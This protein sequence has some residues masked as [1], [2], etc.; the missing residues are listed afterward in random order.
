MH[1]LSFLLFV[2]FIQEIQIYLMN[3]YICK[4]LSLYPAIIVTE[5][6]KFINEFFEMY[7]FVIEI[8]FES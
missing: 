1:F 5:Q 8:N 6:K 2:I 4:L 7:N 3:D